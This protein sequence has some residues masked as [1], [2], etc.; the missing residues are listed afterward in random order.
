MTNDHSNDRLSTPESL[1][2]VESLGANRWDC[3]S[4][5]SLDCSWAAASYG[6]VLCL[7]CSGRHRGLGVR[8]S[9]VKSLTMDDWTRAE[10]LAM[11]EGGNAQ[12]AS[13]FD[14]HKMGRDDPLLARPSSGNAPPSNR[15]ETKAAHFYRRH[16]AKHAAELAGE[17]GCYRGRETSRAGSNVSDS[18]QAA[19]EIE[20][21]S[22]DRLRRM[23]RRR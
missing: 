23:T 22:Q 13:F 8:T 3:N 20:C 14:R 18:K 5:A 17:A 4:A 6:A 15:Y 10:V 19:S 9:F 2:H 1:F 16:L 21:G 11:L 7:T 12:L